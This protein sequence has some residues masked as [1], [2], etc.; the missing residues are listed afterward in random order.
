M[1]KNIGKAQYQKEV[2]TVK[3][4]LFGLAGALRD[5]GWMSERTYESMEVSDRSRYAGKISA[6]RRPVELTAYNC[7]R[8][9]INVDVLGS[10]IQEFDEHLSGP[11]NKEERKKLALTYSSASAIGEYALRTHIADPSYRRSPKRLKVISDIMNDRSD[12]IEHFKK[13]IDDDDL[14]ELIG[15]IDDSAMIEINGLR[16]GLT[17]VRAAV[18]ESFDS[19]FLDDDQVLACNAGLEQY[20]GSMGPSY[21]NTARY[22]GIGAENGVGAFTYA[23][24]EWLFVMAVPLHPEK[25]AEMFDGKYV[26]EFGR[27]DDNWSPVSG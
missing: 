15:G 3:S 25:V 14:K 10:H 9:M 21:I 4:N 8:F 20:I 7:A 5:S 19:D 1:T 6:L 11:L 13:R 2:Q 27:T 17:I 16:A 23:V 12:F 26:S 22:M 18:Q 24:P